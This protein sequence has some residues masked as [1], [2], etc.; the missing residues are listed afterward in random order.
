MSLIAEVWSV[1]SRPQRRRVAAI[2]C[3]SVVMAFCT[4]TGIAAIAPFFAVLG[5]PRLINRNPLLH[6]LYVN[7]D[8]SSRRGF[9]AALGV[10]FIAAVL[11]ANAVNA[12]GTLSM[13]RLSLRID[14]E[15]Q[16]ALFREYLSRPYAFHAAAN[17][18]RLF[19]NIMYETTRVTEGI[20]QGLLT[21]V[22]NL[23]S[24]LFIVVSVL[25]VNPQIS[26]VMLLGLTGGYA[27]IYLCVRIRLL[28]VGETHS[29]AWFDKA[30]IL[31]ES[32]GAI[33][34]V[35]LHKDP[36]LFN[37][38]FAR[39]SG[40]ASETAAYIHVAGQIP[41]HAMECIAV[42]ALVGAALVLGSGG[43]GTGTWLGELTFIAFA[44]YR[45]LPMLQQI[46]VAAV[47]IRAD[48]AAL[49]LIAPDLK[50]PEEQSRPTLARASPA[51]DCRWPEGP[52][53]EIR[54]KGVSFQYAA[55]RS[56]VLEDVDLRI[57]ARATVGLVGA[58][59]SG[60]TT[61]MDVIAGLLVPTAGELQIDGMIL[62]DAGRACWQGRIAYVPQNIFLLDSSIAQN[63]AFGEPPESIDRA[64]LVRAAR[65]AQLDDFISRLPGD[66]DHRV[67]ERGVKL[68]GGQRQRLGIARA[69]YKQAPVLLLDE[70]ASSLDGMTEAELMTALQELRGHCTIVVIAHRIRMVRWCDEIFQLEHGRVSASGNYDE[71]MSKSERFRRIIGS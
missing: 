59:G 46:Y 53:E 30:R 28:R 2:Q 62:D 45:L 16:R 49:T 63:I 68:S 35:L 38:T 55:D 64:R 60:K 57:P 70:A 18:T 5:D 56:R 33:R 61:L 50:R 44:A 17:S 52:C 54:I 47:R 66:Y 7:G 20:L 23:V 71:L 32:F 12:L 48:R 43:A 40:E 31:N 67:G 4:V 24:A 39:A 27:V 10:A 19:N 29:R 25:L 11:I 8:F 15:M 1:L 26:A 21:L 36:R 69:L 65:L 42:S 51:A 41:K 22:T 6:W 9:N 3:I 13:N 34:E 58:N 14:A 37:E